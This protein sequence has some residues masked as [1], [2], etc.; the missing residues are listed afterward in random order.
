MPGKKCRGKADIDNGVIAGME[1]HAKS[2]TASTSIPLK[3][4]LLQFFM[5]CGPTKWLDD[6][7]VCFGRVIDDGLLIVRKL[8]N[9]QVNPQNNKPRLDCRISQC[10]EM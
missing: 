10:G 5:T 3:L 8:E 2:E 6:K 9:V 7:H 4:C 1:R